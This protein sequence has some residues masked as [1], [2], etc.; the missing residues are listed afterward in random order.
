MI[1]ATRDR[2]AEMTTR[3]LQSLRKRLARYYPVDAGLLVG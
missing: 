3:E 1:A 2:C